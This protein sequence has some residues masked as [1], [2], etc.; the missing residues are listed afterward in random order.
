MKDFTKF[1]LD[2]LFFEKE[3][4]LTQILD[5]EIWKQTYGKISVEHE[6]TEKQKAEA[7]SE[8]NLQAELYV[9]IIN[10]NF[11]IKNR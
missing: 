7:F 5:I 3:E 8:G 2:E 11:L 9:N 10:V 1:S 6:F 4:C